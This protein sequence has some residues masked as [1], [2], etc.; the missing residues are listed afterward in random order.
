MEHNLAENEVDETQWNRIGKKEIRWKLGG[1]APFGGHGVEH[2]LRF[3]RSATG[4]QNKFGGTLFCC[5]RE[6]DQNLN[7]METWRNALLVRS[8]RVV[9][10]RTHPGEKCVRSESEVLFLICVSVQTEFHIQTS[11]F[12]RR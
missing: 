8:G 2:D 7:S 9:P 5:G 6:T 11:A 12:L 10:F 3:G 4:A 1:T